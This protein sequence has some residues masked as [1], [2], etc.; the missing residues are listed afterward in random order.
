VGRP[1]WQHGIATGGASGPPGI[2]FDE[3][4]LWRWAVLA[5]NESKN[6]PRLAPLIAGRLYSTRLNALVD[7]VS[8]DGPPRPAGSV[9]SR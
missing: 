6:I 8:K 5:I 3:Q 7:R 2:V 1:Y 9:A 4:P